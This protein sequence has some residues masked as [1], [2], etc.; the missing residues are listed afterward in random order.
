MAALA[1]TATAT[2]LQVGTN[3]CLCLLLKGTVFALPFIHFLRGQSITSSN[4]SPEWQSVYIVLKWAAES[5]IPKNFA[6]SLQVVP[7]TIW[8]IIYIGPHSHELLQFM[9][10]IVTPPVAAS[11]WGISDCKY[12]AVCCPFEVGMNPGS[13]ALA[14]HNL[15]TGKASGK[16]ALG[17]T[18]FLDPSENAGNFPF[19]VTLTPSVVPSQK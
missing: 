10:S 13:L 1:D 4:S 18:S 9:T 14:H 2:V 19:S 6:T 16:C 8:K 11:C 12:G 3:K 17:C 7:G 5:P 15:R